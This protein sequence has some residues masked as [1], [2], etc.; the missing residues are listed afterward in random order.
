VIVVSDT[1]P[2]S[3]LISIGKTE[4]LRSLFGEVLIPPAVDAELSFL[5]KAVVL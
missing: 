2:L 4:M 1:S 5:R 3:A